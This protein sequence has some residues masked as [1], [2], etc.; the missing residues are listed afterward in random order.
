MSGLVEPCAGLIGCL[1]VHFF[2]KLQPYALGFAAG[3]MVFVVFDDVMPESHSRNQ[4][5]TN[6]NTA[7][8]A[9]TNTVVQCQKLI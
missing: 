5:L 9:N 4:F 8:A 7:A 3:A 1:A 2:R 6:K